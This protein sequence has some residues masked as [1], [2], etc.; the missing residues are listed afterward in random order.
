MSGEIARW[1]RNPR[2]TALEGRSFWSLQPPHAVSPPGV[3]DTA[4]PRTDIDRFLL[5][6]LEARGLRPVADADH[7]ALIRRVSFDLVGLP[8]DPEEVSAFVADGS[9][10]AFAKVVD[11]CW[12]HRG[13]AS[14]G[15]GTGSTWRG[16]PNRAARRT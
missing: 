6:A 5:A 2:S 9:D 7:Y 1:P 11:G 4:W 16:M 3:S 8:P 14:A 12:P 15:G 13:S 10:D